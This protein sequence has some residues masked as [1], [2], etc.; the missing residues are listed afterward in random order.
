MS[1]LDFL[2]DFDDLGD[3]DPDYV[4]ES[5]CWKC[6]AL[7]GPANTGHCLPN[8]GGCCRTFVGNDEIDK[9]LVRTRR[10]NEYD[11]RCMTDDEMQA[12]NYEQTGPYQSWRIRGKDAA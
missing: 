12:K 7:F 6:D 9:H 11:I 2:D 8:T 5:E 3:E 10:G 4:P 1:D